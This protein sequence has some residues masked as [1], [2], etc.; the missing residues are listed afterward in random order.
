MIKIILS[1]LFLFFAVPALTQ[2]EKTSVAIKDD[3]LTLKK[4][5]FH[6]NKAFSSK[7]LRNF[8]IESSIKLSGVKYSDKNIK[9][10]ITALETFYNLNGYTEAVIAGGN[11]DKNP[12]KKTIFVD[13]SIKEGKLTR[14]G[15]INFFGNKSFSEPALIK[16]SGISPKDPFKR[17]NIEQATLNIL[18]YY[19]NQGYLDA[20]IQSDIRI[21]GETKKA[22]V[23][24]IIN[25]ND[26]FSIGKID[27]K[28]LDKTKNF[29]V[30]RELQFNGGETVD[31]SKILDSQRRIYLTGLFRSVYIKAVSPPDSTKGIKDIVV[32]VSEKDNGEVNISIGY[33]TIER[34]RGK[35][36]LFNNNLGGSSN[37]LGLQT[38]ASFI[39]RS[40]VGSY[41]SPWIFNKPLRTDFNTSSQFTAEPGFDVYVNGLSLTVGHQLKKYTNLS[42]TYRQERNIYKHITLAEKP[43]NLKNNTGS[44]KFAVINDTRDNLFNATKGSYIGISDE[45]GSF[46]SGGT[47]TFMRFIGTFKWFHPFN[48]RTV[49]GSA[50]EIGIIDARKGL[51]EIP[52]SERFYGGGPN[53]I[54]GFAYRKLGPLDDKNK[55]MGGK[56]ELIFNIAEIRRTVYKMLGVAVFTDAGNIWNNVNE[57]DA[58]DIRYSAGAGIRVSTP[59]G[60]LRVDYSYKLDRKPGES[61]YQLYFS[62]GQAF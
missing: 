44:L 19:A 29:V 4:V 28:G 45:L 9:E 23:D 34:L 58:A 39:A 8:L 62:M 13:I 51:A 32:E 2:A 20:E 52:L 12:E 5:S 27:I 41:T 11:L 37:K 6:G 42:L 40:V 30:T 61:V 38:K 26:K 10:I 33:D 15:E 3:T 1:I 53:S 36:E 31:Y 24:F 25:E 18:S 54:R 35:A 14:I 43:E 56:F 49:L 46:Y 59:V 17:N 57:F 55:P 48:E 22:V 7:R 21:T 47:N 60:P 16:I 50:L